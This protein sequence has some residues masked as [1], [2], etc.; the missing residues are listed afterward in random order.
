M[1][2][3]TQEFDVESRGRQSARLFPTAGC[4][5]RRYCSRLRLVGVRSTHTGTHAVPCALGAVFCCTCA[6]VQLAATPLFHHITHH[7]SVPSRQSSF[8]AS[9]RALLSDTTGNTNASVNLSVQQPVFSH[10]AL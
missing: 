8:L 10:D 7:S 3:S 1:H 2:K 6:F 5:R 4:M 9:A